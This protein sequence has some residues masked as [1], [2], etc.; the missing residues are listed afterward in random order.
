[1]PK[2]SK[3]P[4][5]PAFS[6]RERNLIAWLEHPGAAK[7]FGPSFHIKLEILGGLITESISFAEVA[8]RH[9]ITRQAAHKVGA[10]IRSAYGLPSSSK[11]TR[12][13]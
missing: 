4:A 7:V 12:R 10:N 1:M 6:K 3:T 5:N 9:G 11:L 8:R 2:Q 13:P